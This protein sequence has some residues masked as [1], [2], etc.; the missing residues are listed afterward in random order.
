MA[1]NEMQFRNV[2]LG[3][4]TELEKLTARELAAEISASPEEVIKSLLELESE[5]VV[6][7]LNGFWYK[8]NNR[9]DRSVS[10][11]AITGLLKS[12]GRMSRTELCVML[13]ITVDELALQLTAPSLARQVHRT[14]SAGEVYYQLK[15]QN[16]RG[17]P[18]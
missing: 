2:I 6:W 16:R 15:K 11:G 9:P 17:Q 18:K 5:N 14:V 7:Q 4:I 10:E 13:S 1:M 12:W 8:K 3:K